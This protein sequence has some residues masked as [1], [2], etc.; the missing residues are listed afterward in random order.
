M[1]LGLGYTDL[2][3]KCEEFF[4]ILSQICVVFGSLANL[5]ENCDISLAII[6]Q[7]DNLIFLKIISCVLLR[8]W[9][10]NIYF[11]YF[12]LEN[13]FKVIITKRKQ[14]GTDGQNRQ[15]FVGIGGY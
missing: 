12:V 5:R 15:K 2:Q 4:A 14:A 8:F 6:L 7:I 10:T 1:V 13:L 9:W 3:G 11:L